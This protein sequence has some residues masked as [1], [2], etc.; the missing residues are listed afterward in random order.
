MSRVTIQVSYPVDP[1]YGT[2]V[3]HPWLIASIVGGG[4]FLQLSLESAFKR[5]VFSDRVSFED[6]RFNN[7][8]F[9]LLSVT[10]L[11][12]GRI[13]EQFSVRTFEDGKELMGIPSPYKRPFFDIEADSD[14][15]IS[16]TPISGTQVGFYVSSSG[17]VTFLNATSNVVYFLEAF[18]VGG[19]DVQSKK[20]CVHS[21]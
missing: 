16:Q 6:L 9:G 7:D 12:D 20:R 21:R 17:S 3:Y 1:E 19:E 4:G 5:L 14:Y 2:V 15:T 11:D 13:A 18:S 10:I 8:G